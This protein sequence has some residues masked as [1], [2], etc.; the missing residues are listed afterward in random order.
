MKEATKTYIKFQKKCGIGVGD[1]VTLLRVPECFELGWDNEK[2]YNCEEWV[3]QSGTVTEVDNLDGA[4]I[5]VDFNG[6]DYYYPYF[7]LKLEEKARPKIQVGGGDIW[8]A[9]NG[10]KYIVAMSGYES[11]NVLYSL[12]G[13]PSMNRAGNETVLRTEKEISEQIRKRRLD[14]FARIEDYIK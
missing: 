12:Y 13:F 6:E 8:I 5:S 11:P 10:S 3:G 1:K 4:G 14:F 9:K 7:V 2:P